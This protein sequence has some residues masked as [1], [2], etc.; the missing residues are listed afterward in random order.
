MLYKNTLVKIK[1][2]LGRF[3]SLFGI[4]LVGA[5]FFAGIQAS[6]PDMI[7]SISQYNN[8]HKLMDFKIVSTMGLTNDDV[9]A[10]KALKNVSGVTPSY[11]LDV[12]DQSKAIRVHAI[13]KSVDTVELIK[14]RMPN[15]DTECVAD[16]QSYKVGD[17]IVITSDVS[18]LKNTEFSVVGTVQSPLYLSY[19]YGNTTI[20]DGKLSSFIFVNRENF[21]LEAYTEI[22]LNAA[23]T[24]NVATYSKEYD[25]LASQLDNELVN[26]KPIRE[27]ARYKEVYNKAAGEIN[28]NEATLNDEMAKGEKQ[29]NDAKAQLDANSVKLDDAKKEL[30]KNE[31]DLQEKIKKQNE[32]FRSAKAQ[33]ASG[34]DQITI[35][36]QQSGITQDELGRKIN[37]LSLAIQSMKEQQGK[38]PADNPQYVQ[39]NA[40]ISQY[41]ALS[42]QLVELRASIDT[43]NAKEDQLNQGI[44]LFNSQIRSV[45]Q[46]IASGKTQLAA[47]QKKLDDGYKQ[48]NENLA[49][50]NSKMADAK[51]KVQDARDKLAGAEKPQWTILDRDMAVA[52]YDNLNSGANVISLVAK[53]FPIFFILIVLLMTS[54]T[55][56]RMIAEERGELGTL[57]SLGYKDISII[58]TY[59]FYV[60]SATVSATVIGYFAG[61]TGIPK[62]IYACFPYILPPLIIRYNI[63]TLLL[64]LVVA[65]GVMTLV[66]VVFCNQELK[67]SPASLM[68]PVPPKN[69]QTI[70]LERFGFIWKRL[71]FTWK[72]TM[73]NLFRYKQRVAMTIIGI[74]GCTA[75]LLTGF[76]LKDSINGIAQRQYGGIFRY[77]DLMVLKNERQ[78]I[79]GEFAKLLAKEQIQ[80]PVLIR[81][82]AFTC[83]S[84][85]KSLDAY[86]IVPENEETFSKYFNL[87]STVTGTGTAP[88]DNGVVISNKLSKT[89]KIGKGDKITVKD[90]DNKEYTLPVSDVTENHFLDYIYMNKSLYS[91]IFGKSVSYNIIVSDYSGNKKTL[92]EHMISSDTVINVNFKDNMLLQA[93]EANKSLSSAVILIVC[94]ASILMVIVLYNLT[95][96]N[97]S[98]RK[99]EIASLKVLGFSDSETNEYIYREALILT[100]ISIGLG[101]LLGLGL[102]RFV[103]EIINENA[104]ILFFIKI[105]G[106]SFVWTILIT[107]AVSIIMQV[108]TYFKLQ[109]VDMIES[110]K[111]VE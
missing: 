16:N 98:E 72:V 50:F 10:L 53:F 13:E 101:L 54:N 23:G 97:I 99:R 49:S 4:V 40:Q 84:E 71:S 31:A 51:I 7:T 67:G 93:E 69:G 61:C 95:S 105:K 46:Q 79:S 66:T 34:R 43:L 83:E 39:L 77:G 17:K 35:S 62:I 82:T 65:A 75:M 1:K 20:G 44:K 42:R 56:T 30:A 6:F 3:L 106:L 28:S 21:T 8:S 91:K 64:I 68:R 25:A 89:F 26:L 12:L 110:L 22:Y 92:A 59:L 52:G 57:T 2:S 107:M 60:L 86:L 108:V 90:A 63:I 78:D 111:S 24:S 11:S 33:I 103:M 55:M 88:D 73:R 104:P 5:G 94:I 100:F 36:L 74:A 15:T 9:N 96:I 14:G 80:N 19:D 102:H 27:D 32:S 38:I 41:T 18:G 29:L 109:K 70:L 37:E 85:G 47:N 48:Y 45:Q 58:S 81:Q 87:T 76:G